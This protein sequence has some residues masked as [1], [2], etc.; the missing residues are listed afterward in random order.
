MGRAVLRI[1]P[2][3]LPHLSGALPSAV[4]LVG[5]LETMHGEALA[6]VIEG[7]G[8][9]EGWPEMTLVVHEKPL[10]RATELIVLAGRSDMVRAVECGGC[11]PP[12]VV[13]ERPEPTEWR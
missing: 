10:A 4:K 7:A 13:A 12:V 11:A 5:G 2:E 1:T 8:I 3:M 6:F 9:P